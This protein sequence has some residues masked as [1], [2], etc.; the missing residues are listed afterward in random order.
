MVDGVEKPEILT[1]WLQ[2]PYIH[3][4]DDTTH[5]YSIL[6]LPFHKKGSGRCRIKVPDR[7]LVDGFKEKQEGVDL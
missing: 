3:K 1:S 4:V 7:F 5:L 6:D 2:G